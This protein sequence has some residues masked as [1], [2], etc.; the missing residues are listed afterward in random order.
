MR[1]S[2]RSRV[3]RRSR[4]RLRTNDALSAGCYVRRVQIIVLGAGAIG[5]LIGAKLS[6]QSE[7]ILV[8]RGAN[9]ATAGLE[10][11]FHVRLIASVEHRARYLAHRYGISTAEARLHNER[12]DAA[13]RRYVR[14]TFNAD[15]TI[16][17][18]DARFCS[19]SPPRD[20]GCCDASC[21]RY[22]LRRRMPW[23]ALMPKASMS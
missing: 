3:C 5:S 2:H 6:A 11:G 20:G 1:R 14:N 9:F 18:T 23:P 10:H 21:R 13:R 16:P 17:T 15:V 12:C 22:T 4:R 7:V 19:S 8:G